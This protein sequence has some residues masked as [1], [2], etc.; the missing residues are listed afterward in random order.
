MYKITCLGD[1]G[2]FWGP[3]DPY[4]SPY[5]YQDQYSS[6]NGR[7]NNQYYHDNEEYQELSHDYD[8]YSRPEPHPDHYDHEWMDLASV[9]K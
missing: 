5:Q 4:P 2:V 8:P 6:G 3:H 7:P 1:P 9:H